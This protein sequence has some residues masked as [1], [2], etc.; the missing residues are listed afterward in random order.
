MIRTPAEI[1]PVMKEAL[2]HAGPVIVGDHV[3]YSDNH[4]LFEMVKEDSI[5][6][7]RGTPENLAF[8]VRC[9]GRANL[10][11]DHPLTTAIE[12]LPDVA[13]DRLERRSE[14][15]RLAFSPRLAQS[16]ESRQGPRARWRFKREPLER[17]R[18]EQGT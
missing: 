18:R 13:I 2:N 16:S 8:T 15:G 4:K 9:G 7:H 1:A 11:G 3:D 6:Y 5:H 12:P 17:W 10:R 14:V